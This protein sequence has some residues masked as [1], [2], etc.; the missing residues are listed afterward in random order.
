MTDTA[1][2]D[3]STHREPPAPGAVWCKSCDS[4]CMPSGICGCNN[5]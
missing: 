2:Q 5:R 3:P 4:W 1:T